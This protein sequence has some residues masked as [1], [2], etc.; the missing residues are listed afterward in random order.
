MKMYLPEKLPPAMPSAT[1]KEFELN[2]RG[3]IEWLETQDPEIKYCYADGGSCLIAQF[4]IAHGFKEPSVT[5]N[6]YREEIDGEP[7]LL[8]PEL[9][10]IAVDL[11]RDF[12]SALARA[13]TWMEKHK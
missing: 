9:N 6:D 7:K 5:P 8:P 10:A 11:P 1:P 4:L 3:L 12:G 13:R 2:V